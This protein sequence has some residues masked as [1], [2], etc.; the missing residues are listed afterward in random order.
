MMR[1]ISSLFYL[2]FSLFLLVACDSYPRDPKKSLRNVQNGILKVGAAELSPWVSWQDNGRVSGAEVELVEQFAESLNTQVEW[3]KGSEGLLMR[4]LEAHELHLVIGGV[5]ADS[6]WSRYVAFTRPYRQQQYVI[7]STDQTLSPHKIK[8]QQVALHNE[9][10]LGPQI[11]AKDGQPQRLARLENYRGLIAIPSEE[12]RRY[13]C[14]EDEMRLKP[15]KHV[16]AVPMGENALLMALEK[17]L[18]GVHH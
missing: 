6:P 15:S 5:T 9:S 18:H 12:R 11:K 10:P 1:I 3:V 8:N 2:F 13:S 17:F 4:M 16:M 7:C 14:A